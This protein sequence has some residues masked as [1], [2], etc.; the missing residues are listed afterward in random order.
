MPP[1]ITRVRWSAKNI[2]F[3]LEFNENTGIFTGTPEDEGKYLVPVTVETNYGID[4][5]NVT[6]IVTPSIPTYGLWAI[7]NRAEQWSEHSNPDENGFYRLNVPKI[8][9]LVAH[10]N[11][12]GALTVDN[13]YYFCGGYGQYRTA[14]GALEKTSYLAEWNIPR[15]LTEIYSDVTEEYKEI[16]SGVDKTITLF[17]YNNGTEGSYNVTESGYVII[18]WNSKLAKY[19]AYPAYIYRIKANKKYTSDTTRTYIQMPTSIYCITDVS[20]ENGVTVFDE[21]SYVKCSDGLHYL[22]DKKRNTIKKVFQYTNCFE[23]LSLEGYLDG[24]PENFTHG[25]IRD[26]WVCNNTACVQTINNQLYEYVYRTKTWQLLGTYDMRKIELTPEG[27]IFILTEDGKLCY[28]GSAIKGLIETAQ[29][30]LTQ[31]FPALTFIDFTYSGGDAKTLTVL[32][33]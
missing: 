29:E 3:G 16:F 23:Y 6:L 31:I 10:H 18:F 8:Q 22:P 7:G 25:K 28:K 9:R 24:S 1:K 32:R 27:G 14:S 12:F 4:T 19:I 33:E 2:P 21:S 13:Q 15:C 20:P 5:K 30:T 17:Y 11:G 26:A